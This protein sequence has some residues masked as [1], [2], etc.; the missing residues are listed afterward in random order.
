[1]QSSGGKSK[2]KQGRRAWRRPSQRAAQGSDDDST[3]VFR[4][5]LRLQGRISLVPSAFSREGRGQ[6]AMLLPA[7]QILFPG[8][9]LYFQPFTFTL[10]ELDEPLCGSIYPAAPTTLSSHNWPFDHCQSCHFCHISPWFC[11]LL[12][13]STCVC[14]HTRICTKARVMGKREAELTIFVPNDQLF[15]S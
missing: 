14:V 12:C 5:T 13:V 10:A 9:S 6:H 7:S 2:G 8:R 11:G 3:S 15:T 4:I 1:M